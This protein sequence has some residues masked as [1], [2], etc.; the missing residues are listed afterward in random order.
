LLLRRFCTLRVAALASVGRSICL[1]G[2]SVRPLPPPLKDLAMAYRAIGDIALS[3]RF[4]DLA[5]FSRAY[6]A[7][8]GRS[9]RED[10]AAAD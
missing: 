6:R 9:A 5:H 2:T 10:R 7:R 8:Y 1:G 4:K 3:A